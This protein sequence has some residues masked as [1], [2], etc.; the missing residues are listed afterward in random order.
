MA[1]TNCSSSRTV[2]T[3]TVIWLSVLD[4]RAMIALISQ[5]PVRI[6][7]LLDAN[8]GQHGPT[9]APLLLLPPQE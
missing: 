3:A 1:I 5:Q 6:A 4:L 2:T 9:T 7:L 8:I